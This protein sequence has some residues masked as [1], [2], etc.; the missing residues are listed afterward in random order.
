MAIFVFV[1]VEA[2]IIAFTTVLSVI[3]AS[4]AAKLS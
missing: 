4:I 3:I 2:F 1:A